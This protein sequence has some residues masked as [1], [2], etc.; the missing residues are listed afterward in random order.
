MKYNNRNFLADLLWGTASAM[1]V[2]AVVL[3]AMVVGAMVYSI[4]LG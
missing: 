1:L 3:T 4:Y 2:V